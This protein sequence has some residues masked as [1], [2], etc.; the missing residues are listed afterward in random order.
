[1]LY[2]WIINT[3]QIQLF[4]ELRILHQSFYQFKRYL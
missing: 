1:M 2:L 4:D 3:K